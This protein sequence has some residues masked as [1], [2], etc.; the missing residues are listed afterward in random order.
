MTFQAVIFDLDGTLIA[1][2]AHALKIG[3]QVFS[4]HGFVLP[5]AL[6]CQLIGRDFQEGREILRQ[7]LP[8]DLPFDRL[9]A[10]WREA[11]RLA[12]EAEGIPLRPGALKLVQHLHAKGIPLAIATSS[13]S[14]AAEKKLRMTGLT[15][16]FKA[17]ITRE[18]VQHPKPAPDAYSLA[19]SR[20]GHAPQSCLAFEDS[21]TGAQAARLSGMTVVQVPDLAPTQGLYAHHMAQSLLEGADKLGLWG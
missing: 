19:A 10:E 3:Q 14:F 7:S 15:P 12:Y 16:Y 17:V 9:D 5:E 6:F 20:L 8:A 21:D 18:D 13:R 4:T 2:E 11:A 1:S